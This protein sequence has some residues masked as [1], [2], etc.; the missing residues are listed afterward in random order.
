[1]K[2]LKMVNIKSKILYLLKQYGFKSFLLR[3]LFRNVLKML[4][5]NGI[6]M[7]LGN[8]YTVK[9]ISDFIGY[10]SWGDRHN[11]AWAH[12]IDSLKEN[13]TFI[14]I[15]ANIGL[16][17]LPAALK[18][19]K[20]KVYAFEPGS[21]NYTIL[22]QHIIMNELVNVEALNFLVG[23]EN[24]TVNF[25]EDNNS[26]SPMNSIVMIEKLSSYKSTMKKQVSLDSYF[27]GKDINPDIIKIDVE[28]AELLVLEGAR[29]LILKSKPKIYLST[30]P[31]RI[32]ELGQSIAQLLNI[33]RK[34]NYNIYDVNMNVPEKI[35]LDEYIL[36]PKS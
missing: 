35:K 28:G 32:E 22:K 31:S 19:N 18:L 17:T 6:Q 20:G 12:C 25:F 3:K 36:L 29:K 7:R 5:P 30:H 11:K 33:I 16:Y 27:D 21:I 14:D 1:M 26:V 4:Y 15:G 9:I 10:V 8:R 24:I 34:M 2:K 13:E 23:D